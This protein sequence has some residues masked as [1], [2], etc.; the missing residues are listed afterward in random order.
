MACTIIWAFADS[1]Q[2]S[3][4]SDLNVKSIHIKVY[5]NIST[6]QYGFFSISKLS[7]DFPKGFYVASAVGKDAAVGSD[8]LNVLPVFSLARN[9]LSCNYGYLYKMSGNTPI[10]LSGAKNV[11]VLVFVISA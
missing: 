9:E 11:T 4:I 1:Y 6:D 8:G 5:S 3:D 2:N 10:P 7:T